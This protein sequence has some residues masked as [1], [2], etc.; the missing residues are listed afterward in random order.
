V[1]VAAPRSWDV[2][3]DLWA[4]VPNSRVDQASPRAL[5][6]QG[7]VWKLN[8]RFRA[9]VVDDACREFER[10]RSDDESM[11]VDWGVGNDEDDLLKPRLEATV[12]VATL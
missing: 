2:D 9:T 6:T 11:K 4:T 8:F 7:L 5:L 3:D 12:L 10:E 1:I